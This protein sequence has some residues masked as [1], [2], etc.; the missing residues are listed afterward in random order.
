M[1]HLLFSDSNLTLP[2]ILTLFASGPYNESKTAIVTTNVTELTGPN[3][4]TKHEIEYCMTL[5]YDDKI[6]YE[7]T[8]CLRTNT[9]VAKDETFTSFSSEP[10]ECTLGFDNGEMCTNCR[11]VG[12]TGCVR[13]NCSAVTG[14]IVDSCA[15]TGLTGPFQFLNSSLSATYTCS[16]SGTTTVVTSMLVMVASL[17]TLL[18]AI[19]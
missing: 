5:F 13:A 17:A 12:L 19:A 16:V 11:F 4:L 7:G 14:G 10:Q 3:I 2:E 9:T 6:P 8:V 1:L 18:W 15:A